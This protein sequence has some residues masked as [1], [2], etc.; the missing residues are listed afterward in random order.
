MILHKGQ[1]S[2]RSSLVKNDCSGKSKGVQKRHML[3]FRQFIASFM[4]NDFGLRFDVQGIIHVVP[5]IEG[6]FPVNRCHKCISWVGQEIGMA[7]K[8]KTLDGLFN[9]LFKVIISDHHV[10]WNLVRRYL[11]FPNM[12]EMYHEMYGNLSNMEK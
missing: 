10:F 9:V 7:C 1:L 5:L 12:N 4:Q 8:I 6:C 2:A 11:F 3:L